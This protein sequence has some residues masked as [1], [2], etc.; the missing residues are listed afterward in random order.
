M[1][2]LKA[3]FV[4]LLSIS[5]FAG[6][7]IKNGNF[8]ITYTDIIV[9]GG[10]H[11]I[12]I[13]RTYNSKATE[14]GWFG[15]GWGSDYETFLTVSPDGSVVVHENGAGAL[16]RFTPQKAIDPVAAAKKVVKAMHK[17]SLGKKAEEELIKKLAEDAEMRQAYARRYNVTSTLPKGSVLHASV[18]GHQTLKKLDKG[19]ERSFSDGKKEYFNEEGKLTKIEDKFGYWVSI[20]YDKQGHV[21]AIKD[22]QAKQLFFEW[23]PSGYVKSIAGQDKKK[24]TYKYEGDN[25]S[26]SVDIENN[27]FA[28]SYDSKHNMTK[29][30]YSDGSSMQMDY[31]PKTSFV[32]KVVSRNGDVTEYD[33][34]SNP[35][36]PNYHY[37][38]TITKTLPSGRKSKSR[39]EYEIKTRADGSQYTYRI[40]T[41][42]NGLKTDT[43]YS[44]CCSLPLKITRGKQTTTFEYK[45]GL[46]TKK[47]N[48]N[49]ERVE[50]EYHPEL[51]K[52]TKVS[53]NDGWTKFDYDKAGNLTK[54][55]NHKG[56]AVLLIYNSK[57]KITTMIDRYKGKQ[58]KLAFRYNALGKPVE[59]DLKGV[60]KINVAYDNH[61]EIKKVEPTK[62]KSQQ[63]ALQ[64]T[65][66]FQS[67]LSIVKPAGVN[68]NI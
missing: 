13:V 15:F 45:D 11:D 53:N 60:G 19:Y 21:E 62:G 3:V 44:E 4:F 41:E 48:S 68:L 52:I 64:V 17:S 46:L 33:Y 51:R 58:R 9:P 54:A 66:A 59:I 67:L 5:V 10:G 1:K 43:I 55:L 29:I 20:S 65:Q 24:S 12:E 42:I 49:G 38:T 28:Y 36:N 14:K 47:T 57:G 22:S 25:L 6:V 63:M 30:S 40:A 37:W 39:Y 56:Q 26:E 61:G 34:D 8:Y 31:T 35:K 18:R 27:K 50:L 32:S 7:N 2:L 23:Y 16:T